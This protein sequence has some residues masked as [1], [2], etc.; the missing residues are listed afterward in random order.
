MQTCDHWDDSTIVRSQLARLLPTQ[1]WHL[2]KIVLKES[3]EKWDL[4]CLIYA[5]CNAKIHSGQSLSYY[6][7]TSVRPWEFHNSVWR[8]TQEETFAVAVDQLR[9]CRNVIAH[10]PCV[11]MSLK[12]LEFYVNLIKEALGALMAD[13]S[14][15]DVI[16]QERINEQPQ[17]SLIRRVGVRGKVKNC[18]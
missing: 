8:Q 18:I 6:Y 5:I 10:S 7:R 16:A 14:V 11:G 9:R 13:T 12:D 1:R 17:F 4:T 3:I 2:S 15:V